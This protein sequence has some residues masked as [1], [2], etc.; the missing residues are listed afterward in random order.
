MTVRVGL[1]E[2]SERIIARVDRT[3]PVIAEAKS[4]LLKYPSCPIGHASSPVCRQRTLTFV[5]LHVSRPVAV[6]L[7][8][9]VLRTVAPIAFCES[10]EPLTSQRL[11]LAGDAW[12][13]LNEAVAG[14]ASRSFTASWQ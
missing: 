14:L 10:T 7:H 5:T 12:T 11:S 2:N 3:P 9:K 1:V 6:E 4:W 8:E 13:P